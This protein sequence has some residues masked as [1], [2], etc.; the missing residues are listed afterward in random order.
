MLIISTGWRR[1][2]WNSSP[3]FDSIHI[4][5]EVKMDESDVNLIKKSI[6]IQKLI[7]NQA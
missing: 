7:M 6:D 1:I 3:L 5:D 2:D 4:K